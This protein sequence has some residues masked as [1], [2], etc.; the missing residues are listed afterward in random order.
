MKTSESIWLKPVYLPYLQPELTDEILGKA[1]WSFDS[2]TITGK[3][4]N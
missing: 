3:L 4:K 2:Q 1:E